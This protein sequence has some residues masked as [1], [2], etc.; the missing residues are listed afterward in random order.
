MDSW[1][2]TVS[3][4]FQAR[5]HSGMPTNRGAKKTYL[6]TDLS[7]RM[8]HTSSDRGAV[9]DVSRREEEENREVSHGN[10]IIARGSEPL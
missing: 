5:R 4:M 3:A 10:E 9:C 7:A 6:D 1:Q 2:T 8:Q